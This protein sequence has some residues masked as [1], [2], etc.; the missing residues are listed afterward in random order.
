MGKYDVDTGES[1]VAKCVQKADE[2]KSTLTTAASRSIDGIVLSVICLLEVLLTFVSISF[3]KTFDPISAIL[4]FSEST[5][6]I[7]VFY[8]FIR[9]GKNGRRGIK[10][11]QDA[12][13]AWKSACQTV[14]NSHLL[15]AFRSYCDQ[16][17]KEDV[18]RIRDAE[19]ERLE[20]LYVT[21]EEYEGCDG[22]KGY[23]EMSKKELRAL[24]KKG[25][26]TKAVYK[27]IIKC[28]AQIDLPPYNANLI[29]DGVGEADVQKGLKTGDH[30]ELIG[31]LLKPITCF[32][33][34]IVPKIFEI[35]RS[36]VADPL[37][38]IVSIIWTIF[39][40][41]L[42]AFFG[43]RFG[44]KCVEREQVYIEARTTFIDG[45][46]EQEGHPDM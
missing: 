13:S 11:F 24:L 18:Q 38:A 28:N 5:V 43:Y 1:K 22:K 29:L 6:A 7:L 40:L 25:N 34:A 37:A 41:C 39:S 17:T 44:W 12:L 35:A 31:V 27:Q 15:K 20:N 33:V 16:K 3:S 8:M 10:I 23:R 36:D 4:A 46:I 19:I 32:I 45:F 26:I 42:A 2:L 14:R 9:P 21:R 30:Y